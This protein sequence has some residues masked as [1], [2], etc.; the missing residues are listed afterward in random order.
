MNKIWALIKREYKE[1]V[2]KKSFIFITLLT[3]LLMIAMGVVPSLIMQLKSED[4]VKTNVIDH[5]GYIFNDLEK[6]LNDTLS[7]GEKQFNLVKVPTKTMHSEDLLNSQKKL[8]QDNSID[9]LVVIPANVSDSG[10]VNFFAMSVSDY[11]LNKSF[12]NAIGK[13]VIDRRIKK[14]GLDPDIIQEL[15]RPLVMTTTK[16]TKQGEESETGFQSEYFSTF[17]LIMILYMTLIMYGSTIMRSI[18]QEKSSRIIEVLLG[19]TN[20]FQLMAGKIIGHGSVGMTQYII[21]ALFGI[22][23]VLYGGNVLPISTKYFN[24]QPGIFIYFVIFYLL[25]YLFYSA[26]FT[27]IGSIVNTDQEAQQLIFP[28]IMFLIVPLMMLGMLVKSPNSSIITIMSMIPFFSPIMMFGRINISNPPFIEIA[29][30][31][32]ILIFST[33]A[34]IWIVSKIFRVGILMYGKRPTFPEI[35]KWFSY[36]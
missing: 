29:G 6:A 28:V 23:M 16:I 34:V 18:I 15:S 24:F 7:T 17:I 10:K 20:P 9:A 35:I 31:I 26:L 2:F 36:K 13:I 11:V 14:S 12:R 25:G 21:W 4:V 5:T 22:A 33:I 3:P 1:T 30:S 19:S 8:I 27:A 32:L